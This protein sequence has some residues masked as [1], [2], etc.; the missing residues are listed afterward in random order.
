MFGHL[1]EKR[2]CSKTQEACVFSYPGATARSMHNR[3][4]SDE[5]LNKIDPQTV[6]RI[7]LL[8]G[9]NDID[10]ILDSP[11]DMRNKL[12]YQPMQVNM[13]ALT[14]TFGSIKGFIEHLHQWAPNAAIRILKVL[15][16]ESRARNEVISKINS[17]NN[18]LIDK[19]SYVKQCDFEKDRFLFANEHGYRKSAFFSNNGS[20]NVHL[21]QKGT[22]RLAN[23]LKYTAHNC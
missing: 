5:R 16:R 11:R 2:L 3:F 4:R 18:Q 6:E 21:N 17:F 1:D 20:D 14:D 9:T 19:L 13:E 12:I 22:V 15:P 23:H 7:F 8:C 10:N